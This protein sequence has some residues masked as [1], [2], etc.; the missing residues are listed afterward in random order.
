METKYYQPGHS[1]GSLTLEPVEDILMTA[2]Q[3]IDPNNNV[4]AFIRIIRPMRY[5]IGDVYAE[6][7]FVRSAGAGI[8]V[9]ASSYFK[10]LIPLTWTRCNRC[11]HRLWTLS[12]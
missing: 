4:I 11:I 12:W 8:V 9:W 2:F 10:Q 6:L 7:H 3:L 5:Q 1:G